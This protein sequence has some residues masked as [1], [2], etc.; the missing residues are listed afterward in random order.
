MFIDTHS[1]LS[2]IS[3]HFLSPWTTLSSFIFYRLLQSLHY[4]A[5]PLIYTFFY[6]YVQ[7]VKKMFAIIENKDLN[8]K[9]NR[10]IDIFTSLARHLRAEAMRQWNKQPHQVHRAE[11]LCI[12]LSGIK[13]CCE[14]SNGFQLQSHRQLCKEI[15]AKCQ[16]TCFGLST[17]NEK[18]KRILA[19][20]NSAMDSGGTNVK[21][22]ALKWRARINF[23]SRLLIALKS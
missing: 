19:N 23:T 5:S 15:F 12:L 11:P 16:K 8:G 7:I 9:H 3:H 6:I 1:S 20:W 10:R 18:W 13:V 21:N 2:Q 14:M 17:W 4:S 22:R